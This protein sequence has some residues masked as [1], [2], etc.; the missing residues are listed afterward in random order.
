MNLPHYRRVSTWSEVGELIRQNK[1]RIIYSLLMYFI[2][3]EFMY[4]HIVD[5]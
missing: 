5:T 2:N 1:G 4:E 3:L